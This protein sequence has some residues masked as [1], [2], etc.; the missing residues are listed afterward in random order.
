[1]IAALFQKTGIWPFDQTAIEDAA[2]EPALITTTQAAQPVPSSLPSLLEAVEA[3]VTVSTGI[4][5]QITPTSV[6]TIPSTL[7]PSNSAPLSSA[8]NTT[9]PEPS[10]CSHI[11]YTLVDFP[12]PIPWRSSCTAFMAENKE[13]RVYCHR[14]KQQMEA[15]HASKN[16]MEAENHHFQCQLFG[17]TTKMKQREGGSEAHHMTAQES[18]K[19]LGHD[20]WKTLMVNVY[21]EMKEGHKGPRHCF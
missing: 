6:P 18:I 14:A 21:K 3:I 5:N 11:T 13:L 20:V 16:L 1:M 10:L 7:P 19:A 15:D 2:F 4:A 8:S 12:L 17:K 9:P